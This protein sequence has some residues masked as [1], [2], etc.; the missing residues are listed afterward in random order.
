M[1]DVSFREKIVALQKEWL[2]DPTD[3]MRTPDFWFVMDSISD[4]LTVK[5]AERS[6]KIKNTQG[7]QNNEEWL[8][9]CNILHTYNNLDKKTLTPG[10][11]R[12]CLFNVIRYWDDLEMAYYC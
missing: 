6:V 10:Q 1:I 7:T 12:K 5:W 4:E 11:K 3:T 8:N 9:V 2:R